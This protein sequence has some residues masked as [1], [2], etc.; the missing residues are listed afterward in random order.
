VLTV[1][2]RLAAANLHPRGATIPAGPITQTVESAMKS[3]AYPLAILM[4]ACV[5]F[6]ASA[7]PTEDLKGSAQSLEANMA[8]KKQLR[9][10]DKQEE[11]PASGQQLQFEIQMLTSE[12][13]NA[14]TASSDLQNAES[15]RLGK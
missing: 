5:A 8:E 4:V 10:L 7:G 12:I 14:E 1:T 11:A 6:N 13:N 9:A 2:P 15:V 3:F